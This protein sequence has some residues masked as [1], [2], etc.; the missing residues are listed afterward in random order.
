[1]AEYGTGL[2]ESG[3][4]AIVFGTEGCTA[5]QSREYFVCTPGTVARTNMQPELIV[6]IS[7]PRWLESQAAADALSS[8][9]AVASRVVKQFETSFS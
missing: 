7:G 6:S 1:M 2:G 9:H 8:M 3:K 4:H 5:E